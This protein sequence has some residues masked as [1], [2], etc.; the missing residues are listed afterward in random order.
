MLNKLKAYIDKDAFTE[1]VLFQMKQYDKLVID[2]FVSNTCN[3]SCSH[4]YFL[5]YKP[6]EKAL[7]Y[8]QWRRVL[9]NFAHYGVKHFHFSGK[10]PF[11]DNRVSKLLS[12]LDKEF[13]TLY[14]GLVTNGTKADAQYINTLLETSLSYI[15]ISIEGS[16]NF[17]KS[18]RGYDHYKIVEKLIGNINDKS[19]INMTSTIFPNNLNELQ[20]MIEYF[21]SL[22]VSKFN[23]APY[24][25]FIRKQFL[26]IQETHIETVMNFIRRCHSFLEEEIDKSSSVDIRIC[27]TPNQ[28]YELFVSENILS[29]QI[30]DY[31]YKGKDIV[32]HIG[33]HIL[34][35]NFPLLSIPYMSQ[36]VVTHDG[37]TI[38]CADDIHYEDFYKFSLGNLAKMSIEDIFSEREKFILNYININLKK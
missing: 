16:S 15:E 8:E 29:P 14:Y 11:C 21:H 33:N 23:F 31:V 26:P 30:D 19:K 28:C 13:P 34:E 32:F 27:L 25:S 1:N 35:I 17:N 12:M 20:E 38:P 24:T 22:G 3:L 5:D 37:Y 7:T 9:R 4:C 6:I 2:S 36:I 10:E 18:I